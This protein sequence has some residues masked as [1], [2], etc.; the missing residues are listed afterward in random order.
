MPL[1]LV[2]Y[3]GRLG[4][5]VKYVVLIRHGELIS[6]RGIVYNLDELL[7]PQDIPQLSPEGIEQMQVLGQPFQELFENLGCR[8][9]RISGSPQIRARQSVEALNQVLRV[10][11][12][13]VDRL[14]DDNYD[15]LLVGMSMKEF[16]ELDL[17]YH[18]PFR[19]PFSKVQKR[20]VT[21]FWK[22][23][24]ALGMGEVGILLSH[25]HPL[26]LLIDAL[27][28]NEHPTP[29]DVRSKWYYLAK[30]EA[31][32]FALDRNNNIVAHFLVRDQR[33]K[34]GKIY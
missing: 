9:T 19:E 28:A 3:V 6:H 31:R 16:L 2:E 22:M 29:R 32:I 14:L 24:R 17:G 11:R 33:L 34:Q 26:A 12:C 1:Q 20:V 21:C 30:G 7:D 18:D 15:P 25:G 4:A 23:A 27:V 13:R 5:T 8:C 10:K